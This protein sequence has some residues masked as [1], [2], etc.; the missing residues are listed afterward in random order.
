MAKKEVP[1]L[2]TPEWDKIFKPLLFDLSRQKCVLLL[3][4]EVA[5]ADGHSLREV[6]REQLIKHHQDDIA[7]FHDRD[8]LFLFHNRASKS[9]VQRTISLFYEETKPEPG[10]YEKLAALPFLM[11]VSI[12]PDHFLFDAYPKDARA[13]FA[14]FNH[15]GQNDEDVVDSWERDRPLVYNLCG[16][17][18][19]DASLV[20]DYDDLFQLLKNTMGT[21]GLPKKVRR[22]LGEARSFFFLGFDFDKWYT[23]LLLRLLTEDNTPMHIA[24]STQYGDKANQAFLLKQFNIKFVVEGDAFLDEL[25]R[26]WEEHLNKDGGGAEKLDKHLV[27]RLLQEG[28]TGRALE[29]LLKILT[30]PEDK[31]MATMVSN[32][33]HKWES[34]TKA[35]TEDSR[36]LDTLYN[37]VVKNINDLATN[38]PD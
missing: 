7:Y 3:G 20:L 8:N 1:D 25:C 11:T 28:K 15:I 4:P 29:V 24:L 17:Y 32:W 26:R 5:R 23:Q 27:L 31:E 33:Y 12:T 19:E 34:D 14:F 13:D 30:S 18:R 36:N 37:R 21:P 10:T 9:E 6:L 35:G 22:A 2:T 38:L 16:S